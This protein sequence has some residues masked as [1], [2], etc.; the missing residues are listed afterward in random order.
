MKKAYLHCNAAT[1]SLL[2]AWSIT[3]FLLQLRYIWRNVYTHTWSC[4]EL[5][6]TPPPPLKFS[7]FWFTGPQMT[8]NQQR[9]MSH[10]SGMNHD[11]FL[12]KMKIHVQYLLASCQRWGTFGSGSR[13]SASSG[14]C[15][16]GSSG[17]LC[18]C[19]ACCSGRCAWRSPT[20]K[21]N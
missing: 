17:S 7:E 14:S 19:S 5:W 13:G 11:T 2:E 8:Q 10:R 20:E 1:L 3:M 4:Q 12:K 9:D 15:Q 16:S 18:M 6:K 21:T